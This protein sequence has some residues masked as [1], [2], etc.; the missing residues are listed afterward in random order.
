[1]HVKSQVQKITLHAP[2]ESLTLFNSIIANTHKPSYT[3]TYYT[4]LNINTNH[5]NIL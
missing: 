1:M 3:N 4:F 2:K 5:I